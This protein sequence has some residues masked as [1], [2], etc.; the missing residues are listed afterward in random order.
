MITK[1]LCICLV[2]VFSFTMI[3]LS[4]AQ[5]TDRSDE[6]PGMSDGP[7][8]LL[9]ITGVLVVAGVAYMVVKKSK[10]NAEEDKIKSSIDSQLNS[11]INNSFLKQDNILSAQ[12]KLIE[13][14]YDPGEPDGL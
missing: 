7:S 14:G 8:P 13:L 2:I 3:P 11:A 5:W 1:V 12:K 10:K 6:L 9:I 4:E